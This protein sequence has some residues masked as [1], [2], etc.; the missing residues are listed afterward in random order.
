LEDE[1]ALPL[2]VM[3]IVKKVLVPTKLRFAAKA[4]RD[5][6]AM[7]LDI[8][9]GNNSCQIT[10]KW[11]NVKEYHG[12]DRELYGGADTDYQQ[13]QRVFTA[14]LNE[15]DLAEIPNDTYDYVIMNHVIEHL[16][17]GLDVL[18]KLAPKL[19]VGGYIYIETPSYRTYNYPSADGFLNFYDD[20]THVR[21]YDIH[22]VVD[23]LAMNGFRI[24]KFGTRRDIVRCLL[25]SP[26]MVLLNLVYWLPFRRRLNVQGLWDVLGVATFVFAEK[27]LRPPAP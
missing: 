17:N 25:L 20:P 10:K 16:Q 26:P 1:V 13:M 3:T 22:D 2:Q 19:K 15:S 8:G 6:P 4:L 9:C 7:V 24:L 5:R 12:V 14:D 18:D 27:R 11:L 23:R 21:V